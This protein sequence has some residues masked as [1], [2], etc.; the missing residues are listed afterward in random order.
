MTKGKFS[1]GPAIF[2][3]L[4][5]WIQHSVSFFLSYFLTPIFIPHPP[6]H[7][8][9]TLEKVSTRRNQ[10]GSDLMCM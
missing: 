9:L 4:E 2:V 7:W 1:D 3:V 8:L 5:L 6:G 10:L